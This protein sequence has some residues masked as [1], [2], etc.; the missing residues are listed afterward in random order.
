MRK[1]RMISVL[2]ALW[3]LCAAL[4][5]LGAAKPAAKDCCPIVF[6][7][8]LGGWGEGALMD[9]VMPHWGMMAGS[10]RKE[11]NSAGYE[12]YAASLGPVSSSWDRACE[13]YAQLTGARVDYG[14][15]HAKKYGHARYGETYKAPLVKD[16]SAK[17]P[18]ALLGHSFGGATI[19]LFAQLCE[20]GSAAEKAAGQENLSPLFTGKLKGRIVAIVTLAAPHNGSTAT[21]PPVV[22]EGSMGSSLPGQ[23]MMILRMGMVL[24]PVE[25]VYPFHVQ[26]FGFTADEFYRSP[27]STWKATEAYLDQKDYSAWELTVDGAKELNKTIRCRKGIYYFS[28]AAQAT[29]PDARGNQVPTDAV[30]SMFTASSTAMGKK[31]P[32][33]T[34]PG[35]VRIDDSWLPN[36]GLVNLVSAQYPFGEPHRPY[37][38]KKIERGVWQVMPTVKG[39]DHVDFGGGFTP[40]GVE[41]YKEFIFGIAKML[42]GLDTP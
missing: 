41:G 4:L 24:P 20:Q 42:E 38:A 2:L 37:N 12:A 7:H 31:R 8:G 33:Y 40:G 6:V 32:P 25:R 18:I 28:Y 11:L 16:W 5:G 39:Y 27:V 9:A 34:T 1:K 22:A 35:G 30:W 26:Q 23:L 17:K 14:E 15:A 13:L 36:D 10:M 21:E 29:E 3:M 19:R